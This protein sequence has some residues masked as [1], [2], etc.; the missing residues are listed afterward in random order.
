MNSQ[1]SKVK[2]QMFDF[3]KIF[4]KLLMPKEFIAGLEIKDAALRIARYQNDGSLKKASFVL[5]PGII[6]E[7]GEIKDRARLLASLKKLKEQ[8]E[9]EK[10]K[11]PV[12]AIAPA[13]L[14]YAKTFSVPALSSDKLEQSAELNLQSISPIDFNSSYADWQLLG[15]VEKENKMEILGAFAARSFIDGYVRILEE[16]GFLVA[17]LEF[18]SLALARATKEFGLE[19][20]FSQPQVLVNVSSD[21]IDFLVLQNG[22]LYFEY[23]TPWKLMTSAGGLE[24]REILFEDFKET[25]AREI[26]KVAT[27]YGSRWGGKLGKVILAS[28]ALN[29]EI[30]DLI[31][32]SL[33]LEAADLKLAGF[34]DLPS[35]WF[36]VLG[37]ALRGKMLRSRDNLISLTAIG[38]EVGYFHNEIK[39]FVKIWRNTFWA[40]LG[41]LAILFILADS[42]LARYSSNLMNQS[43]DVLGA[44]GAEEIEKLQLQARDFNQFVNKAMIAKEQSPSWSPFFANLNSLASNIALTR[45]S[46][47][48]EQSTAFLIGEASDETRVVEF[49]NKLIQNGFKNV[50]LPLSNLQTNLNGTVSFSL[51]FSLK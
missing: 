16:S 9:P 8:F 23:F 24:S 13:V 29:K 20:D 47:N 14:V 4:S 6:G 19:I 46:V 51:T 17:A 26:K 3:F 49:K 41:F 48:S 39:I 25:I 45:I 36:P 18:P 44:A 34:L 1:K 33:S 31:K 37:G 12:I 43:R 2:S 10:E 15:E 32:K 22:N 50:S 11:I 21:G 38:T 30:S 7:K 27:F 28:Q 40:T 5:E 42:F 35:S